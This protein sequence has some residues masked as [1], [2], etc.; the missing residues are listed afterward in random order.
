[1]P[2]LV[3]RVWG[4]LETAFVN[5]FLSEA[6]PPGEGRERRREKEREGEREF[7]NKPVVRHGDGWIEKSR[8]HLPA[9]ISVVAVVVVVVVA[10]RMGTG[11]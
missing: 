2:V 5:P 8:Q 11:E 7:S 3:E 10:V 6:D 4:S 1:M 9:H